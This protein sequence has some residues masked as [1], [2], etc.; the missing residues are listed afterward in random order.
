MRYS[1]LLFSALALTANTAL[2]ANT[3][4]TV[5]LVELRQAPVSP[6]VLTDGKK[7]DVATLLLRAAKRERVADAKGF[8]AL[9]TR[10]KARDAALIAIISPDSPATHALGKALKKAYGNFL[11]DHVAPEYADAIALQMVQSILLNRRDDLTSAQA[12]YA[13]TAWQETLRARFSKGDAPELNVTLNP[14]KREELKNTAL[15]I[16]TPGKA[17]GKIEPAVHLLLTALAHK[18]GHE[19]IAEATKPGSEVHTLFLSSIAKALPNDPDAGEWLKDWLYLREAR[20]RAVTE[21][22]R[23]EG[24]L[25]QDAVK[26]SETTRRARLQ[27]PPAVTYQP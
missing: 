9:L 25:M 5:Q 1:L 15:Y 6:S 3:T 7:D 12:L 2:A 20:A 26:Q 22:F 17:E 27:N 21:D 13:D 19:G 16:H 4:A 18:I 24:A 23:P 10:Q 11:T 8:D 14:E